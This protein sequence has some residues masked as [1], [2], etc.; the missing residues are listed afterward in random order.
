MYTCFSLS[1]QDFIYPED[2]GYPIGGLGNHRYIVM[3]MH[4]DN[5]MMRAGE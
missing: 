5:P 4:Y 3:Q 1:L 2:V